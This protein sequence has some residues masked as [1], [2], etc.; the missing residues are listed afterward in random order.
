[1]RRGGFRWSIF[2][3]ALAVSLAW[4]AFYVVP[5]VIGRLIF[6][7][8]PEM[9]VAVL[10]ADDLK[11]AQDEQKKNEQE[12]QKDK[13]KER[14][15]VVKQLEEKKAPEVATVEPPK[16]KP[17]EPVPVKPVQAQPVPPPPPPPPLLD[18]RKQMVDQD[19]FPDEQD[20][21][22]AKYL[23][24][25]NHR[26]EKETRAQ[27]TNL[28]RSVEAQ[29]ESPSE[30]N[31]NQLPDPGGK[32]DKVAELENHQGEKNTLPRSAPMR[33]DEGQSQNPE[34]PGPLSM[35]NLTPRAIE[36]AEQ[37]KLR[38]G[39]EV[40][41]KEAG[42]LPMARVGRD[43]ERGQTGESKKGGK[44]KLTLDSHN[45]DNIEGFATAEKERHQAARAELSHKAGHW[46][47]YL[48]KAA[49]M[50]S[51]IEN[52]T[53]DVKPGNQAE[54]GTRASPF[55]AYITAMHRQ[56]HKLFTF[57]FLADLDAKPSAGSPYNNEELWTQ[58]EIVIKGDG[59]VDKVGIV[60]GSGVLAFDVAAIDSV[61]SA[62]PF[63]PPPQVIKS[64]N[65]K[66]YLDWQFHRDERACGT[67]GV[68]PH[69][70]TTPG[71]NSEHDTS[72]TGAAGKALM[73]Q[74]QAAGNLGEAPRSLKR[75]PHGEGPRPVE[76]VGERQT[77]PPP[78]ETPQVTEKAREAAEGWFAAYQ[79]G[80]A[81]W[82]AGWSAAPMTAAGEVVAKDGAAVKALYKQLLAEAP[83]TRT[84]GEITVL[85]P[86]GI[87]GKLGGLPPGGEE[88][89]MLF[90]V[91]KAGT[92]EFILLMKM[93]S[94]GWRVCGIDR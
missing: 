39:V 41:E 89:G 2:F 49:A 72:E 92:E 5:D 70:L 94:Q 45:Y 62:A 25:K 23:A 3:T 87:R 85:T 43:G 86:A 14:Q 26:A 10:D 1:V 63:P 30:E 11:A 69:I 13:V 67:F 12:N 88:N 60:R 75:L 48:A 50:R 57:G 93:S 84:H 35:R 59:T 71:D 78:A 34:K 15:K 6:K 33:G 29:K 31:Q 74:Q 56:I 7:P 24:Q 68:D 77:T 38:E 40:Q 18:H 37:Q 76:E 21:A 9:E 51:S 36:Q 55:A 73:K 27:A 8:E 44:V 83:A 61:M 47:K 90:A 46:D 81:A 58:L 79:R 19:N 42:D 20:N 17:P 91:G 32:K 54:L 16:P 52:F 80:D 4:H 82:L 53:F 66:V 65:G 28:I 64:A 22:D